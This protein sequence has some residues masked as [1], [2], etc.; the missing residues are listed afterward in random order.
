MNLIEFCCFQSISC[1]VN[2]FSGDNP[3]MTF[4]LQV[5]NHRLLG[6]ESQ[7]FCHWLP[8][9]ILLPPHKILPDNENCD[10]VT[11]QQ[12]HKS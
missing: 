2:F 9:E 7:S 8:A 3:F 11:L 10:I 5:S 6:A 12:T 1:W 4:T